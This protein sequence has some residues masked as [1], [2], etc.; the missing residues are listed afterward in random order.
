MMLLVAVA[1][2]ATTGVVAITLGNL[3]RAAIRQ[4]AREREQLINQICHLSGRPWQEAPAD[5]PRT[6][7]ERPRLIAAPEQLPDF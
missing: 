1:S 3:H 5:E 4:H 6:I 2:A 7:P